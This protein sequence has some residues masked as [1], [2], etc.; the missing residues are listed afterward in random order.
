M[1]HLRMIFVGIV[2]AAQAGALE[3]ETFK[4]EGDVKTLG[5][6]FSISRPKGWEPRPVKPGSAVIAAFWS[7]PQ[8]L[9]DNLSL[10]VPGKQNLKRDAVTK[11]QFKS[12]FEHPQMEKSVAAGMPFAG[13]KFTAKQFLADYKYPAG[14]L[15]YDAT[16]KAPTGEQMVRVRNY[17]VYLGNVML[18]V[19][20]YL[21]QEGEA[22]RLKAFEPEMHR[23]VDSLEFTKKP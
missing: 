17:I 20:F 3:L 10:V 8:G 15:D 2:L 4:V 11:S 9:G 21:I 6:D 13:V 12:F 18:Q 23:I 16:L 14:Y 22:D 7:T 1:K 19:Q 5:V